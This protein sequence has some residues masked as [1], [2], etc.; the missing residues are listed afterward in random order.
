MSART[1][2]TVR[3][4]LRR[5]DQS[6]HGKT[7]GLWEEIFT[8]DTKA[9]LDYYYYIKARDNEIYVIEEDGGICSMLQLNPYMV[10]VEGEQLPSV[11]VIAVA[12][13]EAYRSRGY[14][15]AL[16]RRALKD[17]YG[18]KI[19]FT[20]LMP[21][22]EAIY[23]PY[24]FRY[25]YSQEQGTLIREKPGG[26]FVWQA[27]G[28]A[29]ETPRDCGPQ[30]DRNRK[31]QCV[32]AGLWHAE[33]L[34]AFFA[35][36][37]ADLF[38][39]CTVRDSAYYQTM[40]L[41]QKSERGGVRLML[42][43][44]ALKGYYAYASEESL[45]IREPVF[46]PGYEAEFLNSVRDL[47]EQSGNRE[48]MEV[49][50]HACPAEYAFGGKPLIMARIV[51]LRKLLAALKVPEWEEI[52][53]SFAVIDPLITEN[54]RVWKITGSRGDTQLHVRETEDSE[55]VLPIA[56]LTELLFGRAEAE[57]IRGREGVILPEHLAEELEKITKLTRTCFNE[58]V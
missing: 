34:A 35:D 58:V 46:L 51:C 26:M 7:R 31:L 29:A 40:I 56:E 30:P 54:S 25:V 38:Q 6:E 32:D 20:F 47:A 55:G 8:E 18:R 17:M 27:D 19:P 12:T 43:D 3:M 16:L 15:G 52:D 11:Y 53:C 23:T 10:S 42:E 22:A 4:I 48:Q 49:P 24:D 50:I 9:F 36:H 2:R 45:E 21:A 39:V 57:D 13:K 33:E 1:E 44:G 5:L 14:M 28:R 37:C 41:E